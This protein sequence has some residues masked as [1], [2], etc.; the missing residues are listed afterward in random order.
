MAT[1]YTSVGMMDLKTV[2]I[3]KI[4]KTGGMVGCKYYSHLWM[5]LAAKVA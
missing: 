5:F 3:N 2:T 1:I 4:Q